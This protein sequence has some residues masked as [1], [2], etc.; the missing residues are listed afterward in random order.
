MSKYNYN[1]H[2]SDTAAIRTSLNS[3][4]SSGTSPRQRGKSLRQLGLSTR[5]LGVAPS[6]IEHLPHSIVLKM[7][8]DIRA[9]VRQYH[10]NF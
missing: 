10:N 2:P 1:I 3:K 4:R 9:V 8:D 6:Q 7:A 5:D